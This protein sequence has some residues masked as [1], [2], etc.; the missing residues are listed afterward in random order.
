[1]NANDITLRI[2]CAHVSIGVYLDDEG[3]YLT[4]YE[5]FSDCR[6][7]SDEQAYGYYTVD[8]KLQ[9]S[10]L[11]HKLLLLG[12]DFCRELVLDETLLHQADTDG[13]LFVDL[14]EGRLVRAI[15]RPE[16]LLSSSAKEALEY[17]HDEINHLQETSPAYVNACWQLMMDGTHEFSD[18][19][20]QIQKLVHADAIKPAFDA[21]CEEY[22]IRFGYPK[23]Q[24]H[25]KPG[26]AEVKAE[27]A[28]REISSEPLQAKKEKVISKPADPDRYGA[29]P[30]ETTEDGLVLMPNEMRRLNVTEWK[31]ADIL[32]EVEA[33]D[34]IGRAHV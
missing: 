9:E 30:Y 19:L 21:F 4:G 15:T 34:E 23:E 31:Y 26:E 18:A 6:P 11:G 29:K 8:W 32:A 2:R 7:A 28:P 16:W 20:A 5:A 3:H 24:E 33:E 12:N 1:M 27:A 22:Y 14:C 10:L 17:L 13:N 25:V